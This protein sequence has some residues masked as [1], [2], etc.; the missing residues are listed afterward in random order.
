MWC[1][2]L[3]HSSLLSCLVVNTFQIKFRSLLFDVSIHRYRP[4]EE[5]DLEFLRGIS[6]KNSTS[7]FLDYVY[8]ALWNIWSFQECKLCVLL[9]T[10]GRGF[11]KPCVLLPQ[12]RERLV[13]QS[14]VWNQSV[15]CFSPPLDPATTPN[16]S[17]LDT[18]CCTSSFLCCFGPF[19]TWFIL[20]PLCPL[21]IF[22]E[23]PLQPPLSCRHP[24][25]PH[26]LVCHRMFS[27]FPTLSGS[28]LPPHGHGA[29]KELALSPQPQAKALGGNRRVLLAS[30]CYFASFLGA[31]LGNP[32][33]LWDS[34]IP[35]T[36]LPLIAL[37]TVDTGHRCLSNTWSVLC[38]NVFQVL[39][40]R[41]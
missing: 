13:C 20:L 24:P 28:Q 3:F 23:C 41:T 25:L 27:H 12:D 31:F 21:P 30:L 39:E 4:R 26:T 33:F 15:S 8:K 36:H 38:V 11:Q 16:A 22:P 7:K 10:G 6:P 5:G 35:A 1:S 29:Q 14:S 19:S 18:C 32:L 40:K 34:P 2:I 9:R 37:P 17:P